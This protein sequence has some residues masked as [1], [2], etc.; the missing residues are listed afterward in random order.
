MSLKMGVTGKH[1]RTIAEPVSAVI[2]ATDNFK[3]PNFWRSVC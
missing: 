3:C 1:F 2:L